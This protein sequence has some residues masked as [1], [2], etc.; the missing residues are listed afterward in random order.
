MTTSQ[1][2][3]EQLGQLLATTYARHAVTAVPAALEPDSGADAYAA[4][5]AFLAAQGL[6]IG[7][8]KIGAKSEDGPI[9]GA[10]LPSKSI[11]AAPARIRLDE[12]PVLGLEVEIMFRLKHDLAADAATLS[13]QDVLDSIAGIA[14]SVEI[15]SSR[16]QGWPDVPKLN[17]LAD[18]QNHGALV[19]GEFVDY[20]RDLDFRTPQAVLNVNGRDVFNGAGANPAGD[21]RRLLHWLVKHC[22]EQGLALPA[23]TVITAGSYTGMFFAKERGEV[24]ASIAGLPPIRFEI[25]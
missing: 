16:L 1:N 6:S 3:Q 15:V 5:R 19:V 7:G 20:D 25:V 10:P 11:H 12:F 8:W 24:S 2:T 4:Q 18:L 14:A 13:E 22:A 17:Q 23:G 21:P 9:Q